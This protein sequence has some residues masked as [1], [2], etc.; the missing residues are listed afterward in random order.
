MTEFNLSR[1]ATGAAFVVFM[2][3]LVQSFREGVMKI[4]V[5]VT[6]VLLLVILCLIVFSTMDNPTFSTIVNLALGGLVTVFLYQNF[7]IFQQSFIDGSVFF[8]F[9]ILLVASIYL[10]KAR[11]FAV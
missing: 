11:P 9:M 7:P 10:R 1:V 2:L 5:A 8:V 6:G 3:F 4:P